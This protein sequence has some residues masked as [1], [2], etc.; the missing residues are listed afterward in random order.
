MFALLRNPTPRP[1]SA[2]LLSIHPP[3]RLR[4][5]DTVYDFEFIEPPGFG[6]SE[7]LHLR[8]DELVYGIGSTTDGRHVCTCPD[9]MVRGLR[10]ERMCKHLEA[11]TRLNVIQKNRIPYYGA[12]IV[13]EK[14]QF[15]DA[16]AVRSQVPI[17]IGLVGP[18]G[19]GKTFS[20][21]R[22]ATGIQ[23]VSGGEI[24]GIDTE[25]DRMKHYADNFKFRHVQFKEPFGSMDYL[26][27]IQHC[28]DRGAKT[29][30]V[31][32]LSHEHE[33][34]GG[35]LDSHEREM[36]RLGG[37]DKVKMLAWVKPKAARRAFINGLLQLNCNFIF[38]FRA[39]H[40]SKPI[41][42][43]GKT[44]VIDMG[45]VPVSG[46]DIVFEMTASVFLPPHSQGVPAW[47]S[48]YPGERMAMKLPLQFKSI[49]AEQQPLSEEI[50]KRLADWAKGGKP[51]PR[52]LALDRI[53]K[54][55]DALKADNRLSA[56]DYKDMLTN[57][58]VDSVAQM[59]TEQ[60]EEFAEALEKKLSAK[61]EL[62]G[63]Y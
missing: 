45:F 6:L 21:L 60:T 37:S 2:S 5:E 24:F 27:A 41:K 11:V 52:R 25:A 14:R 55:K 34:V 40:I 47:G 49:F 18:S 54:A 13:T 44:E 33:G 38:C 58:N 16:P 15:S 50:G 29:V 36:D 63:A 1:I 8:H 39:K 53:S 3:Y 17:L 22:L 31:D 61:P 23:Q 43:G 56:E 10:D 4:I 7:L 9:F 62:A 57:R 59:N 12:K 20:A 28:V 30:I 42:A 35:M 26:A 19:S 48:D 32:S 46:D 51:D